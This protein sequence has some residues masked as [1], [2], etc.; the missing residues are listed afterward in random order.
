MIRVLKYNVKIVPFSSSKPLHLAPRS[1]KKEKEEQNSTIR[2]SL[3]MMSL[4]IHSIENATISA[5]A[6]R[7]CMVLYHK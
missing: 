7:Y 3:S 4:V 2:Q 5:S 1:R 6:A